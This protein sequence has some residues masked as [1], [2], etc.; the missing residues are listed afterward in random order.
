MVEHL[1]KFGQQTGALS[2]TWIM[3]SFV[4]LVVYAR[5]L[6]IPLE[7]VVD[8]PERVRAAAHVAKQRVKRPPRR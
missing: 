6:G 1:R 7:R 5:R 3:L 4:L 8:N 2:S